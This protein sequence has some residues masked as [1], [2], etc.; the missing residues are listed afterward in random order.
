MSTLTEKAIEIA[1]SQVGQTDHPLHSH[2]G[3]PVQD[4]LASVDFHVPAAWCMAFVYWSF[5]RAASELGIENPLVATAG[6]L[7]A[8]QHADAVHK[9]EA[10]PQVGDIFIMDFGNDEG[11][12]GIIAGI[13]QDGFTLTTIEGNTNDTGA[14]EGFEVLKKV[15]YNR[16]PI[17]GYLRY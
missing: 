14:R 3:H 10:A 17:I 11:H 4:Y 12:T 1:T 13:S 7:Y 6:V 2:W 16:K 8:W 15:R 5:M 9:I